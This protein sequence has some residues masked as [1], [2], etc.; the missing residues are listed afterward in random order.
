MPHAPLAHGV[1]WTHLG[2]VPERSPGESATQQNGRALLAAAIQTAPRLLAAL[3]ASAERAE[4]V[5]LVINDPCR[6]TPTS[7]TLRA[8]EDTLHAE[9]ARIPRLRLLVATGTHRFSAAEQQA[10]IARALASCTLPIDETDWHDAADAQRLAPLAGVVMH[11][12]IA[13]HRVLLGVGSVEPHYFAGLTGAH[14]TLTIG[15]L[16]Q[17]DIERNHAGALEPGSDLL[18]LAGNPVHDGICRLLQDLRACGKACLAI[19]SVA[20]GSDVIAA[21]A[22]DPLDSLAAL[23]PAARSAY[24]HE[25][26]Q[27]VDVAWLRVSG[28]LAR[29]LYQAD[30]ALKNNHRAVRDGGGILLDAECPEGVGQAAFMRL[31]R[32]APSYAA[33][34]DAVLRDGYRLG[35]HKA[36]KLRHLTDPQ[37]R[38]V[39]LAVCSRCL[40][41]EDVQVLGGRGFQDSDAALEWLVQQVAARRGVIVD[42]AANVSVLP[43]A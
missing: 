26:P 9:R 8:L 12:W 11:R 30:K 15:V 28:P 17:A 24:L 38:G 35:D 37:A 19:N 20:V 25:M 18:A 36:V 16:S 29:N 23:L 41:A 5:L 27:P 21:S 34:R 14:K 2:P 39:R 43:R 13:A 3:R 22:G 1:G 33:A 31:L 42:D 32:D 10:F 6:A 40:A 7:L 4:P